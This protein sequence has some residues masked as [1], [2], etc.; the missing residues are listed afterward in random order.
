MRSNSVLLSVDEN[1]GRHL[2]QHSSALASYLGN[3]EARGAFSKGNSSIPVCA[4]TH[5]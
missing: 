1:K 2:I 3:E 5:I 4:V